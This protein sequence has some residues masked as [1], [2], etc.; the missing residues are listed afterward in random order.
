MGHEIYINIF[1]MCCIIGVCITEFFV[2][3]CLE[4]VLKLKKIIY[5]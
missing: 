5:Y 1:T 4:C 2:S 3:E